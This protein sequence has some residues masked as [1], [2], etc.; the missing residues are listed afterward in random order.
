MVK[1]VSLLTTALFNLYELFKSPDLCRLPER[2][3]QWAP[4]AAVQVMMDTLEENPELTLCTT[5]TGN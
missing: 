1:R 4:P 2:E 5:V 3:L